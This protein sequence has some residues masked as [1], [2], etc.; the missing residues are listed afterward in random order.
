MTHLHPESNES[1]P[2]TGFTNES[3]V[4]AAAKLSA[5]ALDQTE[6]RHSSRQAGLRLPVAPTKSWKP[7]DNITVSPNN[8]EHQALPPLDKEALAWA[9]AMTHKGFLKDADTEVAPK[10]E[11]AIKA[12]DEAYN[13][14]APAI[15]AKL[16]KLEP[17]LDKHQKVENTAYNA[18]GDILNKLP[19]TDFAQFNKWAIEY[20][21]IDENKRTKEA[22][23]ERL[24][25]IAGL[26]D[27]TDNLEKAQRAQMALYGKDET[28]P[29]VV[30]TKQAVKDAEKS[31]QDIVRKLPVDEQNGV[32]LSVKRYTHIEPRVDLDRQQFLRFMLD[33]KPGLLKAID[34]VKAVLRASEPTRAKARELSS[35]M[36][37]LLNDR[38][39]ARRGYRDAANFAGD[40]EK[41][42]ELQK[43]IDAI[44]TEVRKFEK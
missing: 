21:K 7:C 39:D 18:A 30:K 37:E 8:E 9:Q 20:L 13:K 6:L 2:P 32:L 19:R 34:D 35:Q 36:T 12:A 24:G 1:G 44:R 16:A 29:A 10:F 43:Q 33:L 27:A 38:I 5:E 41:R 22:L 15:L 25:Q 28:D 4:L 26:K 14:S 3:A 31:V 40:A 17:D 11:A 42:E 23:G